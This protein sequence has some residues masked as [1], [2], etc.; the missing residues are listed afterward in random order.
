MATV[1]KRNNWQIWKD[2]IFALFVREI[3]T[4]FND[5]FG[6][7]WAVINPVIFIFALAY[8]RSLISGE[9]VHTIPSFTFMALGLL[10]IQLFLEVV[11]STAGAI[12]KNKALF[13]F[14][15]VQPISGIVA[16][17]AFNLLVKLLA[18]LV[19]VILM[20]FMG[21]DIRVDNPLLILC[22]LTLLWLIA[23]SIG[24]I[25]AICT[26]YVEEMQKVLSL[27]T[28]PMFFISCVFFSLQ[29]IPKEYWHYLNWN[30]VVHAI[31]LTRFGAYS[32][33]GSNGVSLTFLSIF[34][35]VI[36]FIALCTYFANWKQAISR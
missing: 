36:V 19:I 16:S 26:C 7:A 14:R 18:L 10:M 24:C 9:Q 27:T 31:E 22:C 6:L 21:I 4:G 33:Y 25:F 3:R 12:K 13:A 1:I 8:G 5:K 29:D 28:R 34:T 2:V 32:S 23:M 35:L 17:A 20:Y 30:P 15:Q 11:N